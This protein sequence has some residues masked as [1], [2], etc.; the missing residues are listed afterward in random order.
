MC[1]LGIDFWILPNF[2]ADD[3]G[4]WDSFKPRY[5]FHFSLEELKRSYLYRLTVLF[6]LLAF[7]YWVY[8]QPTEFDSF[9]ANQRA[10]VV[11]R[12]KRK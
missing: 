1:F 6:V 9:V 10:F 7:G 12:G 5:S 11:R 8:T 4:F 2:F 3:L